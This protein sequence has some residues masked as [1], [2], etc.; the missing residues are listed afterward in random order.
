MCGIFCPQIKGQKSELLAK[1]S[2]GLL[3]SQ[4]F[5]EFRKGR[6][7]PDS[8]TGTK[9]RDLCPTDIWPVWIL[10]QVVSTPP[11]EKST[12]LAVLNVV[13]HYESAP[14]RPSWVLGEEGGGS[15]DQ[16]PE[17][18]RD[19]CI[20]ESIKLQ[21]LNILFLI[22]FVSFRQTVPRWSLAESDLKKH[23]TL[24]WPV[25]LPGTREIVRSEFDC[26]PLCDR[27]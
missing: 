24:K 22:D 4:D 23:W 9:A 8:S 18:T 20:C 2:K 10:P 19:L 6:C 27:D 26:K 13:T 5:A 3:L 14:N 1:A 7:Y 12:F 17:L 25:R 16:S 15:W 21:L 11:S